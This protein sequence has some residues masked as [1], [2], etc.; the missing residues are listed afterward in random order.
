MSII[1]ISRGTM[2][3]GRLIAEALAKELGYRCVDR[4]V[5]V[6]KAAASGTSHEELRNALEKPPT[7]L[8]RFQHKKYVYLAIIQAALADEVRTGKTVY[9]GNAGHLLLKGG[10]PVFCVRIIAPMEFRIAMAQQR[11]K[12]YREE[13]V[14]YIKKMDDDR[15]KWTQY[16]YGV[17]WTDPA[18][19]DLVI[20]LEHIDVS[21]AA[22]LVA[23]VIR[24]QTCY[25]FD[26]KCQEFMND[27]A[28]ASRVRANLA[29]NSQTSHIEVETE[30]KEGRV[31]I[32]GN[33]GDVRLVEEIKRIAYDTPGV[34]DI[35]LAGLVTRTQD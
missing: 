33:V 7:L 35:D 28:I 6:E 21:D 22:S 18:L 3:G 8:D 29:L 24:R 19:Y 30:A 13:A 9:Q 20:N 5:I 26:A 1:T 15:R 31:S 25:E 16:L 27:L 4:D 11:L 23:H 10:G 17:D 2:S 32:R 34:K 14:S 12:M